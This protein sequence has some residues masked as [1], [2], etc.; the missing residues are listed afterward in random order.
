L[1]KRKKRKRKRK[2]DVEGKIV[3]ENFGKMKM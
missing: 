1:R 3:R 2:R